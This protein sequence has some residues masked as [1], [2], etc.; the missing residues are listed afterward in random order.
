MIVAS[1]SELLEE[2]KFLSTQAKSDR[3]Y[4][5]HDEIGYNYRMTNILDATARWPSGS[6]IHAL[7]K[8]R[9]APLALT[10]STGWKIS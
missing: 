3:L 6:S 9:T 2:A 7:E 8:D 4:Y 1:D 5:R 10:R